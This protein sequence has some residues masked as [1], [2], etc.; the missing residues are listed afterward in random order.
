[1]CC[2]SAALPPLPNTSSLCPAFSASETTCAATTAGPRLF[3]TRSC[4]LIVAAKASSARRTPSCKCTSGPPPLVTTRAI[5]I[6]L[7]VRGELFGRELERL[8]YLRLHLDLHGIVLPR[9]IAFPVL[10]HQN[11][12]QIR[13]VVE[14]NPEQVEHFP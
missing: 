7:D 11:A 12:P 14:Q 8:V 3:L 6:G 4:S 1:M 5:A 2:A 13:M 9:R 10:G